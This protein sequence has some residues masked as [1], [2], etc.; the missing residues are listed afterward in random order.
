MSAASGAGAGELIGGMVGDLYAEGDRARARKAMRDALSSLYG[1]D[2]EAGPSAYEQIQ[3]DPRLRMAQLS[4]LDRLQREGDAGGMG[5]EDRVAQNQ[6]AA[7]VARRERGTREAILQ[8]MAMRGQGGSG[9]ELAANL[10]NQQGAA[11]RN[12]AAGAQNA[13]DARKRYLSSVMASGQLAGGIRGQDYG[14]ESGKASA[15]DAI[16]RFNSS[17]RLTRAGMANNIRM[18]QAK[19]YDDEADRWRDRGAGLGAGAGAAFG[20]M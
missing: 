3:A 19:R 2:I 6:A 4:A 1:E 20:A 9:V 13:A 8:N 10:T 17:Q 7:D 11:D 18:G 16:E 5:V 12:A 14:E 15:R